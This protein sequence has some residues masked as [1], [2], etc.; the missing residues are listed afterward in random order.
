MASILNVD[1]IRAT[2][3]TNDAVTVDSTG[4]MFTPARPAFHA[5]IGSNQTM[6]G[7]NTHQIIPFNT[8]V[9]NVGNCFSTSTYVFTCPVDGIYSFSL[10]IRID[11]ADQTTYMRGLIFNGDNTN[12]SPWNQYGSVLDAI[13]TG[14]G[15]NYQTMVCSGLLKCSANDTVTALAGHDSDQNIVFQR[16]SQFTGFLVG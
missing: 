7:G 9:F 11:N 3:S 12:T 5:Y 15:S 8:T 13:T 6:T 4:R 2:G 10:Q 14:Q 16:E 1:K